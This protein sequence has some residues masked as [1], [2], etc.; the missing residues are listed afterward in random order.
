MEEADA[1]IVSGPGFGEGV[2]V[3]SPLS[4]LFVASGVGRCG[5]GDSAFT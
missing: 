5:D 1:I 2:G 4:G 3:K